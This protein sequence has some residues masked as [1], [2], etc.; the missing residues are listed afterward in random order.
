[1]TAATRW[2]AALASW[3]IPDE[4]LAQAPEP[5]WGFPPSLFGTSDVPLGALHRLAREV[6]AG[7]G[8]TGAGPAGAG[9]AGA[10]L[11]GAGPAG[12]GSTGGG[13][14]GGGPG[15]GG[16]VL[17][18]G[19]G[20]GAA[21][22]PLAPLAVSLTGVDASPAMLSSFAAAAEAAGVAHDEVLGDWPAVAP[23]VPVADVVVCRNVVYN[24]SEIVPF[25][26]ALSAHAARRV[27]V[28]LTEVHPS[29]PLAP[30]WQR[31]WGLERPGGPN[32]GD[33]AGVLAELGYRPHVES[34]LHPALKAASDDAD[35]VA[36]VRRRLCLA[37]SHD[38]EIV[39]ALAEASR[40][41]ATASASRT[42]GTVSTVVLAWAGTGG[43]TG[44]S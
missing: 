39:A 37:P 22:I 38:P 19:C 1:M 27:V 11:V 25:L 41:G 34:E 30:L 29:V 40:A 3:A 24:V 13:P 16:T 7:S 26:E 35:F 18:V 5:P 20:G 21:S 8:P 12:G 23:T 36:F 2:S 31:F 42:P 10:G 44:G 33:F 17:D 4:I 15:G 9:L 14:T 6:L 32:A 43:G 28:E